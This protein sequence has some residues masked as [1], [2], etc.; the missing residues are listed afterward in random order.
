[1]DERIG[2]GRRAAGDVAG[3]E[4][5]VGRAALNAIGCVLLRLFEGD[6]FRVVEQ[7]VLVPALADHLSGAVENHAAHSGVGRGDA[8]AAARELNGALHPVSVLIEIIAHR[9]F[10]YRTGTIKCKSG[11]WSVAQEF[12]E[13]GRQLCSLLHLREAGGLLPGA[14][15]GE[16]LEIWKRLT[17]MSVRTAQN[18][19]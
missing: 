5:D 10:S 1:M 17:W 4:G 11:G 3:L 15:G 7:V 14:Y 8:D 16:W 18:Q 9:R 13:N 6:D 2:A 19:I 12:D